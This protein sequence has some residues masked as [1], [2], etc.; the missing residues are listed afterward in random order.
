MSFSTFSSNMPP[1][2]ARGPFASL[3]KKL[4]LPLTRLSFSSLKRIGIFDF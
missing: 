4:A 2:H 1:R 3:T